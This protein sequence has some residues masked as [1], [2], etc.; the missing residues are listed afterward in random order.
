M[1]HAFI[2]LSESVNDLFDVIKRQTGVLEL[3]VIVYSPDNVYFRVESQV[4]ET[5]SVTVYSLNDT[6]AADQ[7]AN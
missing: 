4:P 3:P 1:E 7:E 6:A 5:I 2:Y